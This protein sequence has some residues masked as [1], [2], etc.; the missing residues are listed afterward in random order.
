MTTSLGAHSP[1][2]YERASELLAREIVAGTLP[3]GTRLTE[4]SLAERLGISRAPIRHA[5]RQLKEFGYVRKN[6][7]GGYE[8]AAIDRQKEPISIISSAS[9]DLSNASRA[10]WENIYDD[11]E[12]AVISRRTFASWHVNEVAL[13][14]YY[15]VSRT[16]ARDVLARLQQGGVL[17]KDNRGRWFAPALERKRVAELYEL[18][19][20]LEPV[21]L[22]KAAS[23]IPI[24]EVQD[25]HSRL[26]TL[27]NRNK[28][29][30]YAVELDRLEQDLHVTLLS[31]CDNQALL[32]AIS[33]PQT[34]LATNH[35]LFD[36]TNDMFDSEPFLPEHLS[37]FNHLI[38]NDIAK[39]SD[40]LQHHLIVST[41]RSIARMENAATHITLEEIEYL[42][43]Q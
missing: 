35:F 12:K 19:A 15:N 16:I 26:L 5:L 22:R 1:K 40:A 25:M 30:R 42:V 43:M 9:L 37:V 3:M 32:E 10:A 34:M 29:E 41:D 28:D 23:N 38:K 36:W 33:L 14:R 27:M 31:Y 13:A 4:V 7:S 21:A 6:G 24:T 8:V 17:T 2:L 20:V 39:A 11:V 18:R